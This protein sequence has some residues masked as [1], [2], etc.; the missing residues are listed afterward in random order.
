[1]LTRPF[2][3]DGLFLFKKKWG[4]KLTG[5]CHAGVVLMRFGQENTAINAF[6][7]NNP[8]L[9]LSD[10]TIR[11]ACFMPQ[12]SALDEK[13]IKRLHSRY[14]V[15]GMDALELVPLEQE[16]PVIKIPLNLSDDVVSGSNR[17]LR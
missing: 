8:F 5:L 6:L 12:S 10:N 11:G 13:Q 9:H 2:L 4:M 16:E 17:G 14:F 15:E 7:E 1:G 3:N